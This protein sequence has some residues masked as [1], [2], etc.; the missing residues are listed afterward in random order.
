VDRSA[1]IP[2]SSCP[3]DRN[4]LADRGSLSIVRSVRFWLHSRIA[5]QAIRILPWMN[6]RTIDQGRS[7]G[8]AAICLA[9]LTFG[10]QTTEGLDRPDRRGNVGQILLA[11]ALQCALAQKIG[12]A[13]ALLRELHN[14]LG[15]DFVDVVATLGV[16][17][18]ATPMTRVVSRSNLTPFRNEV[19]GTACSLH[20][21]GGNAFVWR[22][23]RR[24]AAE[25]GKFAERHFG[26]P[27]RVLHTAVDV[28]KDYQCQLSAQIIPVDR[29]RNG[30]AKPVERGGHGRSGFGRVDALGLG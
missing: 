24:R 20:V 26:K 10:A 30:R 29:L 23:L 7:R 14:C 3:I 9:G 12:I 27:L 11:Q 13:L 2:F 15:D 19:I 21:S 25:A 22:A 8:H 17:S 18:N 28:A 6:V 1:S 16:I 4:P 5:V